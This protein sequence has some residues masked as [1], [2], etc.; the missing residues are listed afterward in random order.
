MKE[1]GKEGRKDGNEGR[2]TI[3]IQMAEHLCHVVFVCLRGREREERRK[4]R[5]MRKEWKEGRKGRKGKE[6]K[7]EKGRKG[8]KEDERR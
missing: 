7:G 4:E 8:G 5:R 2:T 6:R 3:L 1:G